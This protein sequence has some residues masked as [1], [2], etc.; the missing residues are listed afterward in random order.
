MKAR[1]I[2]MAKAPVAGMAKT[3]LAPRLGEHGAA[4][5]AQQMLF[6]A[7]DVA[8][9]CDGLESVELC[10]SPEPGAPEW[11]ATP[12]PKSLHTSA[13]GQGDLGERMARAVARA[14]AAKHPAA[15]LM[16]TDCPDLT[17]A[18][19]Q[20]ALD[21]LHTHDAAMLPAADGGYV[22]LGL[23]AVHPGLFESVPWSTAAVA[24]LTQ[25]RCQALGLALWVGPT[26]HDI[27]EP[28]DLVHLPQS[29]RTAY[30]FLA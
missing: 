11:Q 24:R 17:R 9:S 27:D 26:L 6:H 23:R 7:L 2:V 3:R 25:A 14:M 4:Q 10:M 19:I 15:I 12:L 30:P 28:E 16:G 8:A 20:S 5:L 21:A 13:Q 22:L 18:H 29:W 1:I